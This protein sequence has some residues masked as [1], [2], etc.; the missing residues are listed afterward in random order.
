MKPTRKSEK[1][2]KKNLIQFEKKNSCI[3]EKANR[4]TYGNYDINITFTA[5]DF[6]LTLSYVEWYVWMLLTLAQK[7]KQE[8]FDMFLEA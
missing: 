1:Q 5:I 4:F 6:K 2:I 7:S 3:A 8:I